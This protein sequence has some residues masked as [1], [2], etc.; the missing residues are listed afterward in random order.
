[1]SKQTYIFIALLV[2]MTIPSEIRWRPVPGPQLAALERSEDEILLGGARGGM[3]TETG[4]AWLIEENYIKNPRYK[5]LIIRKNTAD[6]S[7]FLE[8]IRVFYK[9]LGARFAG[10]P[11]I[12]RFPSGAF[13]RTGHLADESAYEKYVGHEYQKILI[14]E[15]TQ[16]PT[17]S[18]Y[19]KL[20]GSCRSTVPGLA[21]QMMCTTNPGGVGH[22]WVKARWVD[23]A[24]MKT[25]YY[26]KKKNLSRIFIPSTVDD[27]PYWDK[28]DP[29]Y[30]DK[31]EAIQDTKLM[32]AWRYGDWDTFSGQFF[33][34]W[35]PRVHIIKPYQIPREFIRFRGIDWG[36]RD[37]ACCLWCAVDFEKNHIIYRE[38]YKP[39][40]IPEHFAREVLRL[41]PRDENVIAS[42]ADPSI[43][44]KS[45]YGV[46]K[47]H[48]QATAHSIQQKIEDEGLYLTRANNDVKAGCQ[49]FNSLLYHDANCPPKLFVF[50]NCKNF[51]R[52]IP[53]LIHDEKD[54]ERYNTTGEDHA[55]D[56]ARYL[57]MHTSESYRAELPKTEL[58]KKFDEI[59]GYSERV[60][61]GE[62]GHGL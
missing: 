6:L 14:E 16:I 2:F 27:N 4:I 54:V 39:G 36:Y 33:D 57:F 5:S 60:D 31:L 21:A 11:P 42:P 47:Y 28:Y 23:V 26:G 32:R 50:D 49:A 41:S 9:P 8:R 59:E 25:F 58:A 48:E 56:A 15:L 10:D 34:M 13:M 12:I 30:V 29:T 37:P 52:T 19:E 18:Q 7:D 35:D 1:M 20:S 40:V 62:W 22:V 61:G 38:Y 51:I 46:G 24:R 17:E 53:G 45:Q 43:W 44:A 3:K 55:A